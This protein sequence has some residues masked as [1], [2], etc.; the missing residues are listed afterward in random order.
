[1]LWIQSNQGP[2]GEGHL[3]R[4]GL[5]RPHDALYSC[6]PLAVLMP[7]GMPCDAALAVGARRPSR[8]PCPY[9]AGGLAESSPYL[10]LRR[11]EG[12]TALRPPP[13]PPPP[14]PTQHTPRTLRSHLLLKSACFSSCPCLWRVLSPSFRRGAASRSKQNV[15]TEVRIPAMLTRKK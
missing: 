1:M 4:E 13:P 14:L 9:K 12:Q 15:F 6:C 5:R 7:W 10:D 3:R 2:G 11:R 8:P